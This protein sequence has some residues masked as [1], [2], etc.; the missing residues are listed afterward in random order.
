[1]V[2]SSKINKN[3]KVPGVSPLYNEQYDEEEGGDTESDCY[4]TKAIVV[5]THADLYL[6]E[7]H[8]GTTSHA[9]WVVDNYIHE[10]VVGKDSEVVTI[11][12][13]STASAEVSLK[14]QGSQVQLSYR[15]LRGQYKAHKLCAT[16]ATEALKKRLFMK[17]SESPEH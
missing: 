6:D 10:G 5:G 16:G 3:K 12:I 9:S 1:M 8:T 7:C 13:E 11:K 2:S 4:E 15:Q 17:L 14:P